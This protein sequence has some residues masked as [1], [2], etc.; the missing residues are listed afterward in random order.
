MKL[1]LND[2]EYR[3]WVA[4]NYARLDGDGWSA[5]SAFPCYAYLVGH[6]DE[7]ELEV[8]RY[9]YAADVEV[10]ARDVGA[11]DAYTREIEHLAAR[12][13]ETR[14]LLNGDFWYWQGDGEDHLESLVCPVVIQP[15]QLA[16]LLAHAALDAAL[17]AGA[18]WAVGVWGPPG[19]H[20]ANGREGLAAHLSREVDEFVRT[21]CRDPREAA[22]VLLL[23]DRLRRAVL[24]DCAEAGIDPADAVLSKL[25]ELKTRTWG[26]PDAQGVVEHIRP[27]VVYRWDPERCQM[28]PHRDAEG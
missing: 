19:R 6:P 4:E 21:G 15:G 10:M 13:R 2:T 27:R 7:L 14:D 12:L 20:T 5:P 23:C 16:A 18:E 9:L 8:P 1:L 11:A 22:D 25:A 28:M 17:D 3:A 26:V 24:L